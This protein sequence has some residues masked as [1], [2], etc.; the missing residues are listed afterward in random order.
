MTSM[1]CSD[2]AP[3]N[4]LWVYPEWPYLCLML[5]EQGGV[6]V[7][8]HLQPP[9]CDASVVGT[10]QQHLTWGPGPRAPSWGRSRVTAAGG[11][12]G[13]CEWTKHLG[14]PDP[15]HPL[16]DE[17]GTAHLGNPEPSLSHAEQGGQPSGGGQRQVG[18]PHSYL[19]GKACNSH[20]CR[21]HL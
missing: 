20:T 5:G 17:R 15:P 6:R 1:Q 14:N 9:R 19:K 18:G 2:W 8:F 11:G 3:I 10:P 21:T 13:D 12:V 16:W 4:F 7:R